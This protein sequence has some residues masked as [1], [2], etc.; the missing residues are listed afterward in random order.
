MHASCSAFTSMICD[1]IVKFLMADLELLGFN[2]LYWAQSNLSFSSSVSILL[3]LYSDYLPTQPRLPDCWTLLSYCKRYHT[4]LELLNF[5]LNCQSSNL[6]PALAHNVDY[7]RKKVVVLV[8]SWLLD[9]LPLTERG[10]N[11]SH[12]HL[13]VYCVKCCANNKDWPRDIQCSH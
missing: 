6:L 7:S 1:I 10:E 8:F 5:N 13:M 9:R 4:D 2:G 11:P 12:F 3:K